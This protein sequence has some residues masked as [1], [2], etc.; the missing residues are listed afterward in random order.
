VCCCNFCCSYLYSRQSLPFSHFDVASTPSFHVLLLHLNF[1]GVVAIYVT[2]IHVHNNTLFFLLP[3]LHQKFHFFFH[4][5][6]CY[7]CACYCILTC[8]SCCIM[9]FV[10]LLCNDLH[11]CSY[12]MSIF[13]LQLLLHCH[14]SYIVIVLNSQLFSIASHLILLFIHLIVFVF[15]FNFP[16]IYRFASSFV[17]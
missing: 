14:Y 1:V 11:V 16:F 17:L 8:N 9:I 13:A 10:F 15:V 2:S 4:I 7:Y 5:A 6:P 3:M 12:F